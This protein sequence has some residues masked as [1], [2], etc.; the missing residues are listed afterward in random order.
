LQKAA[1]VIQVVEVI[2]AVKV[3]PAAA[4]IPAAA[5][6]IWAAIMGLELHLSQAQHLRQ[7]PYPFNIPAAV[8]VAHQ[9]T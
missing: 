1:G 9:T 4:C 7:G 5:R 2:L 6:I 8:R 3:I